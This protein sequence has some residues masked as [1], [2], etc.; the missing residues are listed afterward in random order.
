MMKI[1]LSRKGLDSENGGIPSPIF[2]GEDGYNK[3]FP[4]PIPEENSNI[5]YSDLKLFGNHKVSEF[6]RDV[7]LTSKI[8][9][10]C[11]L[12]PDIREEYIKPRPPEWKKAFGQSHI[13]QNHLSRQNVGKGDVF[14]FF[15]WYKFAELKNGKFQFIKNEEYPNGFHAIY[16]YLQIDN[17]YDPHSTDIPTWLKGHPHVMQKDLHGYS[18]VSNV[19]YSATDFFHYKGV[20][21]EKQGSALFTFSEDLILTQ[22]G[23]KNRTEWELPGIFHPNNGVTLSYNPLKYWEPLSGNARLKSASKGQEF[24]VKDDP[25]GKIEDWCVDL[26][27]KQIITD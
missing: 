10:T 8:Q 24:I 26:I 17:V 6:L 14:L 13:A 23:Q 27:L 15:G 11:H 7:P 1:I 21:T 25:G 20:R 2:P 12:D 9:E 16:G 3:F 19:I 4:I 22:K 18:N 5:K